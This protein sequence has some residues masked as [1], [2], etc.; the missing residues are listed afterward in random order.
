MPVIFIFFFFT[1][2][3]CLT[4]ISVGLQVYLEKAEHQ[5]GMG[6]LT[7][8]LV[9]GKLHV[10]LD[11]WGGS[12]VWTNPIAQIQTLQ[13]FQYLSQLPPTGL[14]ISQS[15]GKVIIGPTCYSLTFLE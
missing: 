7:S 2:P 1:V 13:K 8:I 14:P 11:T 5:L 6:V 9:L 4:F 3:T 12:L 10:R 15:I